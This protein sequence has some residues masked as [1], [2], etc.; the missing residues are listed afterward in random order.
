[1]GVDRDRF[2]AVD[3]VSG[4]A[5]S[6]A[7]RQKMQDPGAHT[8]LFRQGPRPS[9]HKEGKRW[10]NHVGTVSLAQGPQ[11]ARVWPRDRLRNV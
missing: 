5:G 11:W 9:S 3:D 7:L 10:A 6:E 4:C 2:Q 8:V 1:M